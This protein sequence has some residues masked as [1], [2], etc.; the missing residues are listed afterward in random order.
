MG[1]HWLSGGLGAVQLASLAATAPVVSSTHCTARVCD[2]LAPHE[3]AQPLQP[4][5]CQLKQW[6]TAQVCVVGGLAPAAAQL[7]SATTVL[8]V[9]SR[10]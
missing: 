1:H 3:G 6:G 2:P 8:L 7:A 4:P 5:V 9:V 10:H